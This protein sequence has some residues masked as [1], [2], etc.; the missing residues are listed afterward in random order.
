MTRSGSYPKAYLGD[1][2]YAQY[3]GYHIW[4]YTSDGIKNSDKIPLN[5]ENLD[6]LNKFNLECKKP[7]SEEKTPIP[8]QQV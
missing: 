7:K 1:Q 4:I 6:N 5:Q 8:H 2:V 3:D